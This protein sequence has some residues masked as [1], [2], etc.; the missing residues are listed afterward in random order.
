MLQTALF[1]YV[2]SG[3]FMRYQ[4]VEHVEGRTFLRNI[5]ENTGG[6]SCSG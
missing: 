2:K 4:F 3:D 5:E 1:D 6:G